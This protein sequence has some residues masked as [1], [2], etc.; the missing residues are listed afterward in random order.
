MV[1]VERHDP[2]SGREHAQ[3]GRRRAHVV[4]GQH[5]HGPGLVQPLDQAGGDVLHLPG[6]LGIAQGAGRVLD[7][8]PIGMAPCRGEEAIDDG[9]HW[10][11]PLQPMP[12]FSEVAANATHGVF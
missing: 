1:E 12:N 5:R 3:Q 9:M 11:R 7:R 8:R 4:R 2:A 6:E 10:I